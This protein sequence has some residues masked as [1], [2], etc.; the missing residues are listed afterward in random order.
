MAVRNSHQNTNAPSHIAAAPPLTAPTAPARAAPVTDKTTNASGGDDRCPEAPPRGTERLQAQA[1]AAGDGKPHDIQRL[2]QHER[3]RRPPQA[4]E[5]RLP[6]PHREHDQ[7]RETP[8]G[9]ERGERR[10]WSG[11]R[12]AAAAAVRPAGS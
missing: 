9:R 11:R 6:E 3:I 10:R 8:G 2:G 5:Q 12:G 7:E 1:R 4:A